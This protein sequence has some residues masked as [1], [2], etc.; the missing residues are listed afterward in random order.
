MSDGEGSA[1]AIG[2]WK[3]TATAATSVLFLV[4]GITG[5]M[6]LLGIRSWTIKSIHEWLGL[7]FAV[8][9]VVHAYRH[10]GVVVRYLK[11]PNIW[12]TTAV[13]TALAVAL[14]ALP[15]AGRGSRGARGHHAHGRVGSMEQ[16]TPSPGATGNTSGSG[17]A[18]EAERQ[19]SDQR[20]G[21]V[22]ASPAPGALGCPETAAT[23]RKLRG[24][25]EVKR[26]G[27]WRSDDRGPTRPRRSGRQRRSPRQEGRP[28]VA[29][30]AP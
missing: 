5:V 8:A 10:W 23:A 1:R 16:G 15:P 28:P 6:L 20:E 21:L 2:W 29:P 24:W 4:V 13:V 9:G 18:N 27:G 14:V 25:Q 3:E 17:V 22:A 30:S 11:R 26:S 12:V 19:G 7:G